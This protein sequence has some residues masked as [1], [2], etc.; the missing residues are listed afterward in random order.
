MKPESPLRAYSRSRSDQVAT[1][2]KKA[3]E[4]IEKDIEDNGGLY[5]FNNGRLSLAEVCRRASIHK[6]TLQG[7]IHRT[8]TKL[9]IKEWIE[10]LDKLLEK[11]T[12]KVHKR[13]TAS[14]DEWRDRYTEIAHKYN[15]MYAIQVV[16]MQAKLDDAQRQIAELESENMTLRIKLSAG[17]V[18]L[19][20]DGRNKNDSS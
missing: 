13:V 9:V 19:I 14:A 11:G 6:I 1:K 20:T 12:K 17:N 8:T 3:M 2:L 5:P 18:S 16:S 15:E 4:E 7:K 10:N